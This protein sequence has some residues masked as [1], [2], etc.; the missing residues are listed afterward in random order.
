MIGSRSS[1]LLVGGGR[2]AL[3]EPRPASRRA[4]GPLFGS[5]SVRSLGAGPRHKTERKGGER[6][7]GRGDAKRTTRRQGI[8]VGKELVAHAVVPP[9]R[10][11]S[12]A[13]VRCYQ[14]ASSASV[15]PRGG[16]VSSRRMPGI[17]SSSRRHNPTSESSARTTRSKA[18]FPPRRWRWR[19]RLLRL[20]AGQPEGEASADPILQPR[21]E[22][23]LARLRALER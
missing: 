5:L 9:C 19:G 23:A 13:F 22:R 7:S 16:S 15:A 12:P 14:V 18:I 6:S 2:S 11:C 21:R 3:K 17:T 10:T 8:A 20:R 4:P 1:S